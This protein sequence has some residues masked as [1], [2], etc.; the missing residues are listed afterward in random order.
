LMVIM[1]TEEWDNGLGDL[2]RPNFDS[3]PRDLLQQHIRDVSQ[4]YVCISTVHYGV[5]VTPVAG[6]PVS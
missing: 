1:T 2:A 4:S 6:S 3:Y 5:K